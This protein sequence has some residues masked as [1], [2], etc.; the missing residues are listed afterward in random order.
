VPRAVENLSAEEERRLIEASSRGEAEA[1]GTLV[2][3]HENQVYGLAFQMLRETEEAQDVTQEVFLNF[4]R[5]LGQF[6]FESRL[7]TW[8]YRVTANTVKNHWKYHQRRR[9]ENHVS[10]D[11]R[12]DDAP[13]LADQIPDPGAGPRLQAE[14]REMA[15]IVHERM[16]QLVPEHLEVLV[17][18][19]RQGLSYDEIAQALG[20]S[21][22]TV[23]SR[24]SRARGQLREAM[25][26]VL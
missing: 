12:L 23:K 18:R 16:G 25:K 17:M 15:R 21:L 5:N 6:R 14:N 22:G 2:Q 10:L 11:E 3:A 24:I 7:S 20:C 1:F 19:F 13:S 26:D 8:L 4:F 9:R